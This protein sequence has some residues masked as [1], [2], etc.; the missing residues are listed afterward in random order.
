MLL[1][2]TAPH[3]TV[4]AVFHKAVCPRKGVHACLRTGYPTPWESVVAW[5]KFR[6]GLSR[7]FVRHHVLAW[8]LLLS[9]QPSF[10]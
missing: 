3:G 8:G 6:H 7:L 1:K 5:L 4:A 10:W 9:V 2:Y